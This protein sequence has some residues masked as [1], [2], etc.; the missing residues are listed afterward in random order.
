MI[1]GVHIHLKCPVFVWLV[2]N[3]VL[4]TCDSLIGRTRLRISVLA[5]HAYSVRQNDEPGPTYC[6]DLVSEACML[7][8]VPSGL[9][10]AN[11]Q[12]LS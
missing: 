4:A 2:G 9:D 3:A 8:V 5:S 11:E 7:V 1:L 10:S 6:I 12:L